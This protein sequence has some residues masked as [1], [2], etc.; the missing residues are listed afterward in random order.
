MLESRGVTDQE[1]DRSNSAGKTVAE[2]RIPPS[3][4][5]ECLGSSL[6]KEGVARLRWVVSVFH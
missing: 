1:I 3:G 4:D 5:D 2:V 6:P